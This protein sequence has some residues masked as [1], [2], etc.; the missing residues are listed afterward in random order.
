MGHY[1]LDRRYQHSG[2]K[3]VIEKQ[4]ETEKK[5]QKQSETEKKRDK[6]GDVRDK[7]G[8]RGVRERKIPR[9]RDRKK[10]I[11]KRAHY[12]KDKDCR[13]MTQKWHIT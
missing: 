2:Q 7:K 8:L 4:I 11:R 13:H 10:N 6:E 1:F 12:E 3:G 5:S 9:K